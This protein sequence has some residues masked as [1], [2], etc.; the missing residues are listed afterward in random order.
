M[1]KYQLMAEEEKIEYIQ[2]KR[3]WK[4]L[5]KEEEELEKATIKKRKMEEEKGE[6]VY[7]AQ[8]GKAMLKALKLEAKIKQFEAKANEYGKTE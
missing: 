2:R 6:Q 8:K 4:W 7:R 3:D 5:H 1:A